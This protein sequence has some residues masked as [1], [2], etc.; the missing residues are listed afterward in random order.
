MAENNKIKAGII[1]TETG[2]EIK[3]LVH[4][5][6][7]CNT[8][9]FFDAESERYIV[10]N[11]LSNGEIVAV[12]YSVEGFKALAVMAAKTLEENNQL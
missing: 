2:R 4:R 7:S 9:V 5:N 10:R 6:D 11:Q 3:A 8:A 12:N 1:E